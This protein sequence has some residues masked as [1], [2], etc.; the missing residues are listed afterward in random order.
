MSR[1]ENS[2][3]QQKPTQDA[4]ITLATPDASSVEDF[5]KL[6]HAKN[7][8]TQKPLD[9]NSTAE[10]LVHENLTEIFQEESPLEDSMPNP[11]NLYSSLFSQNLQSTNETPTI[12]PTQASSLSS[13]ALQEVASQILVASKSDGS[14]E[15]KISINDKMLA[16]TEVTINKSLD[17]L[18]TVRFETNNA[19]SFQTLVSSQDILKSTLESQNTNVRIEVSQD[20]Q[21]DNNEQNQQ[22]ASRTKFDYMQEEDE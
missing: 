13:D 5:K 15:V 11:S 8:D 3:N 19:N 7:N 17:G 21:G 4:E 6:L 2:P 14:E 16:G 12:Q 9:P 20:K 18:L 22:Q 10:K 1:I